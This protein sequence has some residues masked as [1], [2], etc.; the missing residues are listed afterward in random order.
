MEPPIVL[1][2]VSK[3][4]VVRHNV[5]TDLKVT[6]LGLFH[7]RHR[8]K[9][10]SF[11]ALRDITLDIPTGETLGLI[12]LNGSGKSTL[13]RIIAGIFAPTAGEVRTTGRIA[14]MIELGVGFHPELTGRENVY[15]NA[16][17][18]GLTRREIDAIYENIVAFAELED[19]VD[20]PLKTY[21]SGM[22]MRLGF[23]VT[24]HLDPDVLL[25][26]EVL[27]VGDEH[28]QQK[29]LA[30]MAACRKRG[31]TLVFVS[32]SLPLVEE[33]C[34]RVSWLHEGRIRETGEPARVIADYKALV[35]ER[36]A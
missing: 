29:C 36:R 27:A 21:S 13:L 8:E 31:K 15:L 4:F 10:G 19:F 35:A 9:R 24:T 34:D 14:T 30:K 23:A 11:W 1:R 16:S 28:F 26:D 22:Q 20:A 5:V 25:V 18:Y 3:S 7:E 2:E 33:V 32:H 12:G 6:F 17:L